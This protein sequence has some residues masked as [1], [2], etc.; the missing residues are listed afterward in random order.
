METTKYK[1]DQKEVKCEEALEWPRGEWRSADSAGIS[2]ESFLR[3]PSY[4][5]YQNWHETNK[6]KKEDLKNE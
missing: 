3:W 1:N 4:D 6:T 5:Q 2:L